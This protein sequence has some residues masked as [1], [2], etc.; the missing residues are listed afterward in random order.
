M[1][2]LTELAPNRGR[3]TFKPKVENQCLQWPIRT[4]T[5]ELPEINSAPCGGT[6]KL[7]KYPCQSA[8]GTRTQDPLIKSLLMRLHCKRLTGEE[9]PMSE[10][11]DHEAPPGSSKSPSGGQSAERPTL[12][13][14]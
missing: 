7:L 1:R 13:P 10:N 8:L 9:A 14:S 6:G 5:Y 4:A 2:W 11:C 3:V 12:Q